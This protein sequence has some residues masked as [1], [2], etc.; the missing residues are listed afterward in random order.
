MRSG[1]CLQLQENCCRF[2]DSIQD[3]IP[4]SVAQSVGNYRKFS[5]FSKLFSD[6][7]S[8]DE[9]SDGT[10]APLGGGEASPLRVATGGDAN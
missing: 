10:G 2:P 9:F 3:K 6:S 1:Q 4:G 5:D 7:F 8:S